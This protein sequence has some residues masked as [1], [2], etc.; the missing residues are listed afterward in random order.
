[1]LQIA[2]ETTDSKRLVSSLVKKLTAFIFDKHAEYGNTAP[3]TLG[4][5][6]LKLACMTGKV[7]YLRENNIQSVDAIRL[8]VDHWAEVK[9]PSSQEGVCDEDLQEY[10]DEVHELAAHKLVAPPAVHMEASQESRSDAFHLKPQIHTINF[11]RVFD[12]Y[13]VLPFILDWQQF[14]KTDRV[15]ERDR[16]P[17]IGDYL[18]YPNAM[19][20]IYPLYLFM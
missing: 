6:G 4:C 13:K 15:V 14:Q 11:Q 8:R 3:N 17:K 18:I 2:L 16:S 5:H 12:F 9:E 7:V 20:S 1:M 10:V 19:L